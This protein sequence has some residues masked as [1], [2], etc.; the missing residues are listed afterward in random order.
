MGAPVVHEPTGP[1]S[2]SGDGV[3]SGGAS[4][5]VGDGVGDGD[6]EGDADPDGDG[7]GEG[8][9]STT[10]YAN[11]SYRVTGKP[12]EDAG[13]VHD[14]D[15]S[16]AVDV[17]TPATP[18]GASGAPEGVTEPALE[19]IPAPYSFTPRISTS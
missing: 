10:S 8:A 2:G 14:T 16:P 18:D 1:G 17:K 4:V 5:S 15:T 7:D 6:S 12:P 19:A 11:T 13:G 9:G 3:G